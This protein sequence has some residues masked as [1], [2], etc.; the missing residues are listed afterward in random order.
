MFLLSKEKESGSKE[1]M[2]MMGMNDSP[3]WL[4]WWVHFTI[5]NTVVS[6]AIWAMLCINII[7]FSSKG[8][9]LVFFWLYGEAIFG[10]ILFLQAFF[11]SSKFAGIIATIIYF[12]ASLLN[13]FLGDG[14]VSRTA[15]VMASLIP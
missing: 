5:L 14:D 4:S 10:Q 8:Y 2:R 13:Q 6:I 3:Y 11:T 1:S 15:K 7:S 9:M 12:G